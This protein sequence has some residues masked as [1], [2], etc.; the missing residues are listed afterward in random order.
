MEIYKY[1]IGKYTSVIVMYHITRYVIQRVFM[2]QESEI[3]KPINLT[4]LGNN[5]IQNFHLV[6]Y[7]VGYAVR[8]LVLLRNIN[9]I[10]ERIS[11]DIQHQIEFLNMVIPK[12]ML[13]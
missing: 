13:F 2:L 7:I 10:S 12:L 8:N 4:L 3:I 5:C 9:M 11:D 1:F 6:R